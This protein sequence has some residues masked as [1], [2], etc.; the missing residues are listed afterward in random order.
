MEFV[1]R[2][3]IEGRSLDDVF[4]LPCVRSCEKTSVR[5]VMRFCFYP[6]MMRHPSQ[7][8]FAETGDWLCEDSEGKWSVVC[9]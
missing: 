7:F 9:E 3:H 1:R 8:M 5:G 4:R 6:L 2:I